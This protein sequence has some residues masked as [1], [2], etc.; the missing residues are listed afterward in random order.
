M[1]STL[2]RKNIKGNYYYYLM[3][4]KNGSL[5]STY[6]GKPDSKKFKRYLFSLTKKPYEKPY[7]QAR[8]INQGVGTPVITVEDGLLV[9]TYKNGISVYKDSKLKIVKI[10]NEREK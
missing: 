4:Y 1:K 2:T 9:Y 8:R 10:V 5:H 3:T 6:L 7:E